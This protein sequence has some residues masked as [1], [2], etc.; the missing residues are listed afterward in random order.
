MPRFE[1]L[2]T[3]FAHHVDAEENGVF[4]TVVAALPSSRLD[5]LGLTIEGARPR[6][7][8]VTTET[9]AAVM[10]MHTPHR[11]THGVRLPSLSEN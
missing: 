11:G 4:P 3:L 6:V 10:A 2:R 9:N 5:E 8:I 7:W 1:A